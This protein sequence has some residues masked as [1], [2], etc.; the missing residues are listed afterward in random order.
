M[1]HSALLPRLR[2]AFEF[3]Q[4]QVRRLVESRPGYYP[5][6]T[7]DGRWGR[8]GELWTHWCDGFLPG[9]PARSPHAK[10]GPCLPPTAGQAAK[11]MNATAAATVCGTERPAPARTGNAATSTVAT[12]PVNSR[13]RPGQAAWP[14]TPAP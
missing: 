6:Y 2:E 12:P 8:E 14:A 10:P 7:V 9:M 4:G 13:T 1:E 11:A 3:A 5:M